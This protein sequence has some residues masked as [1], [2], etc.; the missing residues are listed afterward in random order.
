MQLGMIGLPQVGKR[1]VF[2]LLTGLD[3]DK[4]PRKDGVVHGVAPV[5]DHRIDRLSEMYNPRRTKYAE[6]DISLPDDI[7]PGVT[8][9]SEWLESIQNADALLHVVR[10]FDAP[11]VFHVKGDVSPSRDVEMIETELLLTDLELVEKRLA[12]MAKEQPAKHDNQRQREQAVLERFREH[13]EQEKSLRTLNMTPEEKDVVR[14]LQFLT[15]K[16][17]VVLFNVGE[18]I[19]AAHEELHE[20]GEDLR[21]KGITVLFLSAGIEEELLELDDAERAAFMENIGIDMPAAHR[22]SQA[23]Y[24]CLGLISFFTVGPDEVRAWSVRD[25]ALA[26]E[27]AGKIHSDL[28]RGF[29]RAET[30]AYD[31]LVNAGSEKAARAANLFRENAKDYRVKDGDIMNIRFN[32]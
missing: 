29:I 30:V 23:A 3:A 19:Q 16:P 14:N 21:Q 10:G 4:A 24:E 12:R 27:A 5:R 2:K 32:V 1:T 11:S 9:S 31:D 22:L 25:G 26:P 20:L 8:R 28:E 17:M 7:Q 13:L 15:L 18:D 6:F